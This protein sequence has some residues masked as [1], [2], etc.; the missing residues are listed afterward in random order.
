MTIIENQLRRC[1]LTLLGRATLRWKAYWEYMVCFRQ[2][3]LVNFFFAV[4][5]LD[6]GKRS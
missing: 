3:L 2:H 4:I 5:Y 6:D 1:I